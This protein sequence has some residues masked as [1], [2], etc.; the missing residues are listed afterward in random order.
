MMFSRMWKLLLLGL[1]FDVFVDFSRT[2]QKKFA[3]S[4]NISII[5][6]NCNKIQVELYSQKKIKNFKISSKYFF[7]FLI[8]F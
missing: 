8:V 7:H 1:F 4:K 2:S 6:K 5:E 3:K